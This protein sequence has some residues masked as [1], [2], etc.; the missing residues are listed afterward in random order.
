MNSPAWKY[1]SR[2]PLV[3]DKYA[4]SMDRLANIRALV[5]DDEPL[6]RVKQRVVF[7]ILVKY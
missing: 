7:A 5:V 3:R 2:Y 6:A 1:Q 4:R